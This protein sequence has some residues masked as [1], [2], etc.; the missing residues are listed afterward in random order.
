M[1]CQVV[2]HLFEIILM[3]EC[4]LASVGLVR[5]WVLKSREV[6]LGG[7]GRGSKRPLPL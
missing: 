3:M 6:S 4:H 5:P 1:N 2:C 7:K